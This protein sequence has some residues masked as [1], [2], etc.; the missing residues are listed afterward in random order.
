MLRESGKKWRKNKMP[1]KYKYVMYM[2]MYLNVIFKVQ[3]FLTNVGCFQE[4]Y[5]KLSEHFG[6]TCKNLFT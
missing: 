1:I 2:Y 4:N 5:Y 3:K 6:I